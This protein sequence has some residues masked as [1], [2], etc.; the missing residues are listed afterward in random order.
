MNRSLIVSIRNQ[1]LKYE[2]ENSGLHGKINIYIPQPD[3]IQTLNI[4][5]KYRLDIVHVE[6]NCVTILINKRA[7]KSFLQDDNRLE[8]LDIKWTVSEHINFAH[9]F[10][11]Q[12]KALNPFIENSNITN[13]E[14][15]FEFK[16]K[17]PCEQTINRNGTKYYKY[18]EDVFIITEPA[19]KLY[20]LIHILNNLIW[21]QVKNF[22]GY[23]FEILK[24][25]KAEHGYY[26]QESDG[27]PF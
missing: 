3:V 21:N 2:K 7:D 9:N 22:H 10:S 1:I 13:D 18:K 24:F 15:S 12:F 17:L 6:N 25:Q 8:D 4:L 11:T 19:K 26:I 5:I 20:D 27:I 16:I 23:R 14:K